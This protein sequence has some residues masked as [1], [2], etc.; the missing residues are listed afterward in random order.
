MADLEGRGEAPQLAGSEF[1]TLWGNRP[2]RDLFSFVKASMPP[3]NAG[4][5]SD[6]NYLNV[7]AFLLQAN[8]ATAGAQPLT[9]DAGFTVRSVATG[10]AATVAA[11][12][13]SASA[14]IPCGAARGLTTTGT[15]KNYVP[16]S[17]GRCCAIPILRTG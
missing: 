6:A 5:L 1:M 2:T 16:V 17:E 11:D 3:L 15:V 13:Q 8:G 14:R 7:I 4:S 12:Q 10:K 9:A